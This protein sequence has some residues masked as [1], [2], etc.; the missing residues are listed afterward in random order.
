MN[1]Q[2]LAASAA[3][4]GMCFTGAALA[5]FQNTPERPFY[6][7]GGLGANDDSET[8]WRVFGGFRAH[9][10]IAVELGYVDLGDMTLNGRPANSEA[11]ELVGLGILPLNEQFSV[12][13]KLGAYRGEAR[14][15]GIQETLY[16][17]TYGFGG[18][19]DVTQ[20]L[21]VRLEWQRFTDFGGGGFGQTGAQDIITL[22]AIYR[23]R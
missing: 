20:N 21:G 22:N 8:A 7:G 14:G 12:Y 5:Q 4:V 6:I 23:F 17:F 11:F 9:R 1:K 13:G 15:G 2:W 16:D 3:A 18:Q 10:N 19:Y